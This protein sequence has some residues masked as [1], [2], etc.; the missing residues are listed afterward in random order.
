[1]PVIPYLFF[2]GNC[3]EAMRFYER[4]L[5]GTLQIMTYGEAPE[6]QAPKLDPD[7]IMHAHLALRD[8][9]IMAS[10]DMSDSASRGMSGFMISVDYETVADADRAFDAL[11]AGGRIL[12]PMSKTF[13]SERFGMVTDRYGVGWMV[14][15]TAGEHS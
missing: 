12:M 7:K 2:N 6:G 10:D 4:A 8:G 15:L 3:G 13:W 14:S 11:A 9:S 5:G 1:M